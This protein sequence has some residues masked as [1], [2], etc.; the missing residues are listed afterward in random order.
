MITK[1]GYTINELGVKAIRKMEE[2]Q[3]YFEFTAP[4]TSGKVVKDYISRCIDILH[5][6]QYHPDAVTIQHAEAYLGNRTCK[7]TFD[8]IIHRIYRVFVN[9]VENVEDEYYEALTMEAL[10]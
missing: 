5:G 4:E 10:K 8:N 3:D 6:C 1:K 2:A 7:E 9:Y